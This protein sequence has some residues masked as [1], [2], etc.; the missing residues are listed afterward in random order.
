MFGKIKDKLKSLFSKN[1]EVIEEQILEAP[2]IETKNNKTNV[3][4]ITNTNI[5]VEKPKEKVEEIKEKS[6]KETITEVEI[7]PQIK[8]ESEKIKEESIKIKEKTVEKE[9]PKENKEI[10]EKVEEIKGSQIKEKITLEEEIKEEPKKQGFFSKIFGKKEDIEIEETKK[11]EEELLKEVPKEEIKAIKEQT[12]IKKEDIEKN[13]KKLEK[14]ILKE[15]ESEK[16]EIEEVEEKKGFLSRTF[17]KLK[18]KKIDEDDFDKIW[19]ELQLFLLEINVAYD[20]VEKIEKKLRNEL[21]GN[22]FD[23]FS[24]SKKIKEVLEK[25]VETVLKKRESSFIE[26]INKI[27][28]TGEIIKILI[29]GVNGTGKTTT[30]AKIVNYLQKKDFKVVVAAADTFRAAAVEQLDEHSKKL[31][32][33]LIKHKGGSDPA[34]V[35]F[36]AIEHAKAKKLDIVLID[37]AGRMPNNANLMSELLKIKR[38]SNAQMTIFIGDSISGND[39]IEQIELF[40]KGLNIDGI[41]LTKVDTDEKPGSIVTTAYSIEKPIYFLGIGQ[42]YDDLIEF[43]AKL[44][45]KK[46]FETDE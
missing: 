25:E 22:S 37:T 27:K 19:I 26:E 6:K 14:E 9:T 15:E 46:L 11:V 8:K 38:I 18:S 33:K 10:I 13:K 36:D 40:N 45:A 3:E 5:S 43:D 31:N 35:S 20:I 39:L 24:L 44:I 12:E 41:V 34:A 30:I 28:N 32:F 23:R 16:K 2:K 29:L 42:T 17:E 1:E 7:K 4:P 21:I